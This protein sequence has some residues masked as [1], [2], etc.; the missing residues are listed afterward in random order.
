[1]HV[2]NPIIGKNFIYSNLKLTETGLYYINRLVPDY[3][4]ESDDI[5]ITDSVEDI[6]KLLKLDVDEITSA[7]EEE[8]FSI[9]LKSNMFRFSRF[10]KEKLKENNKVELYERFADYI[11]ENRD[12][13]NPDFNQVK[14]EE[15]SSINPNFLEA[16]EES[17]L[18]LKEKGLIRRKFNGGILK[19]F[20]PNYDMTRLSSTIPAFKDSFKSKR[21]YQMFVIQN[22]SETIVNRFMITTESVC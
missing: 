17:T 3:K 5:F 2:F 12:I 4:A 19:K 9:L 1:M 14:F 10:Q 15:F 16:L 6:C 11:E 21:D 18:W 8:F 13:I 20:Y 7:S 22:D